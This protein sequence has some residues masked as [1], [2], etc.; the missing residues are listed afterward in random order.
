M[1]PGGILRL[2]RLMPTSL[3]KKEDILPAFCN[4]APTGDR[5]NILLF[6]FFF[7]EFLSG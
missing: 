4:N 6:I 2:L 7:H 1:S 5:L 3:P